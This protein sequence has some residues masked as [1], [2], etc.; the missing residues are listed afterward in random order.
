M[1]CYCHWWGVE[2]FGLAGYNA[3]DSSNRDE[4]CTYSSCHLFLLAWIPSIPLLVLP[5]RTKICS[6]TVFAIDELWL[7]CD[8][9]S[10]SLHFAFVIPMCSIPT[11]APL[12][13]PLTPSFYGIPWRVI[14]QVQGS[15][16][17]VHFRC[18]LGERGRAIGSPFEPIVKREFNKFHLFWTKNSIFLST[19]P[20]PRLLCAAHAG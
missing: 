10:T 20:E 1:S 16:G 3:T 18:T 19:I 11:S 13:T 12:G 14:Q 4:Q 7:M 8:W 17:R 9:F 5:Q 6:F 2:I 15:I